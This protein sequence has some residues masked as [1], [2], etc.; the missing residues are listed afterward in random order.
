MANPESCVLGAPSLRKG[1]AYLLIMRRHTDTVKGE[2]QYCAKPG[3]PCARVHTGNDSWASA[4]LDAQRER[5]MCHD[6]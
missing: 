4:T 3:A 6:S 5:Q 1:Y 2:F